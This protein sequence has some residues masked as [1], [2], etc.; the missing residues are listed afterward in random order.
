M[1]SCIILMMVMLIIG[2][3]TNEEPFLI[4]GKQFVCPFCKTSTISKHSYYGVSMTK[5]DTK[6]AYCPRCRVGIITP[7]FIEKSEAELIN[8]GLR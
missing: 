4:N 7:G 8:K 1:K 6:C 2:C 3:R 5:M